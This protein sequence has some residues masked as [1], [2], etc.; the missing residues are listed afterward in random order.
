MSST[1]TPALARER[2][3][4]AVGYY[5]KFLDLWGDADPIFPEVED[6]RQRLARLEAR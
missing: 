3:L 6:A 4:K 5:R 2:R 1:A